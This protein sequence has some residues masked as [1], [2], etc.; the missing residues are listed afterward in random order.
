MPATK[1]LWA[2]IFVAAGIV[3]ATTWGA[4]QWT[5]W[6]LAYQPQ[7]GEPWS[8]I[9]GLPLYP[10]PAFFWWW[11][12]YDAYAPGIFVEGAFMAASGGFVSVAGRHRDVGVAAPERRGRH[13]PTARHAGRR[14]RRSR[15]RVS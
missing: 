12:S 11:F 15:P 2:Q 13:R 3:L 9:G 14:R 7:L 6:R 4:T 10:P 5:A 1:I 8:H